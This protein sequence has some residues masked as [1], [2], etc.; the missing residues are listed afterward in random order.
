MTDTLI[1]QMVKAVVDEVDPELVNLKNNEGT[2]SVEDLAAI[3]SNPL[4]MAGLGN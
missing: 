2:A 4:I 1:H 3:R